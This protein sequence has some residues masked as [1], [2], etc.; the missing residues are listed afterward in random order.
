MLVLVEEELEGALVVGAVDLGAQVC[1]RVE[2]CGMRMSVTVVAAAGD[3]GDFGMRLRQ[4][5]E[6]VYAGFGAVVWDLEDVYRVDTA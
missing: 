3:E 6:F 4:K 1:E 2:C 5:L